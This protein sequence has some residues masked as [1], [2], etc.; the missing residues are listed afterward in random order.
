MRAPAGPRRRAV[1]ILL[2]PTTTSLATVRRDFSAYAAEVHDTHDRVTITRN[3][4]PLVVLISPAELES[5]EATLEV[6]SEPGFDLAEFQAEVDH[7]RAHPELSVDAG[8]FSAAYDHYR[9]HG[10]WPDGWLD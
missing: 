3:G 10:T 9:A 2:M 7:A 5:I 1:K 4:E 6:L 8:A